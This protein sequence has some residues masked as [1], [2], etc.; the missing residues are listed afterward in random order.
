MTNAEKITPL[1]ITYNEAPNIARTLDK[2]QWA[3]RIVV[4]DSFSTDETLAILNQYPQI[5]IYQRPFKSFADQCNFGIEQV[6]SEW[7]LSLD[8][9]YV[10]DNTL[11]ETL[12]NLDLQADITVA[13]QTKFKYAIFGKPLR[14]TLYPPRKVLYAKNKA[15][16]END[17]HGHKIAIE[18]QVGQLEG[19]IYHDDRKSFSHW[20]ASQDRYMKQEIA[21]LNKTPLSNL[22]FNDRIR[23]MIIP[24]PFFVLFYCL[25]LKG[26][27]LDGWHGWYYAFQRMIAEMIFSIRLIESKLEKKNTQIVH[28][29]SNI[30]HQ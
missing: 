16:Y 10:L 13:Y 14:G 25:I 5:E 15:H 6:D 17:G 28:P 29:I 2:L 22:G 26:G 1:I 4:I 3:K 11:E 8:A 21:K 18:G 30:Q 20:L 19:Y 24:A 7:I 9:D 27:I 23:M 12:Q